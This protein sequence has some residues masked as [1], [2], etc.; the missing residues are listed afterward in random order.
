MDANQ[1]PGEVE[2]AA[3]GLDAEGIGVGL[4]YEGFPFAGLQGVIEGQDFL[5][6]GEAEF[7]RPGVGGQEDCADGLGLGTVPLFEEETQAVGGALDGEVEVMGFVLDGDESG[8]GA[9]RGRD[10]QSG[11]GCKL[12]VLQAPAVKGGIA[13]AGKAVGARGEAEFA[14]GELPPGFFRRAEHEPEGREGGL[15]EVVVP[16]EVAGQRNGV[17]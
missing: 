12:R 4:G 2:A 9:G 1:G 6:A 15:I 16:G 10:L 13:R 7:D 8:R 17:L 14:V 3:G 11:G 5:V